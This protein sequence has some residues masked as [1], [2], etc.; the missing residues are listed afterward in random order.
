MT[1]TSALRQKIEQSGL[2]YRFVAEMLG[3]TPYG[4]QKKIENVTEFKASEISK[5]SKLL[6]L[7]A[8]EMTE[9]FFCRKA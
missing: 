5:L 2:K 4:L 3:I 1:N 9:I 6:K 7:S 8:A